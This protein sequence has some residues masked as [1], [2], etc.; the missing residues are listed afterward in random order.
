MKDYIIPAHAFILASR[1]PT[2]QKV[3]LGNRERIQESCCK[4]VRRI[5]LGDSNDYC[6]VMNWLNNLYSCKK[7][8]DKDIFPK[9]ELSKTRRKKGDTENARRKK[10][11]NVLCTLKN[12]PGQNGEANDLE[13][14]DVDLMD[15]MGKNEFLFTD[16]GDVSVQ[17]SNNIA[18]FQEDLELLTKNKV[19]SASKK[20]LS[21]KSKKGEKKNN[22]E[23]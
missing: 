11:K 14:S 13:S 16:L 6:N 3:L 10:D 8:H 20:A 21:R 4:G 1:S 12:S 5:Q 23:R 22:K 2:F 19:L 15:E 9:S 18:L 17:V 7:V